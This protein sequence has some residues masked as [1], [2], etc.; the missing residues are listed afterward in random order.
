MEGLQEAMVLMKRFCLLLVIT[1][2]GIS[3]LFSADPRDLDS[4]IVKASKGDAVA[5][6]SLGGIYEVGNGVPKD[7]SKATMWLKKALER[8]DHF[9]STEAAYSLGDIYGRGTWSGQ[10]LEESI[11]YFKLAAQKGDNEA[12]L[13]LGMIYEGGVGVD[14]DIDQAFL[15]YERGAFRRHAG[16]QYMVAACY[17]GGLGVEVNFVKAYA[18]ITLARDG[19][20]LEA[21]GAQNLI[22]ERISLEEKSRAMKLKA[23]YEE[24]IGLNRN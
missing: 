24:Q 18:W 2:L 7:L 20:Y 5:A 8:G 9:V 14:I 1:P 3:H 21:I 10:D 19:G 12:C 15:W 16:S 6:L 4:K 17:A 23:A 13:R 11:R 22:E